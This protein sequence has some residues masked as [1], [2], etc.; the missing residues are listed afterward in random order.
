MKYAEF[1]PHEAL[2]P[3][4]RC[5]WSLTSGS[6]TMTRPGAPDPALPDGCPELIINSADPFCVFTANGTPIRQSRAL[7]V[8]QITGPLAVGPTGRVDLFAVRF[9]PHGAA[10]VCDDLSVITD[11]WIEV[12]DL[13]VSGLLDVADAIHATA[14]TSS[15]CATFDHYLGNVL[16]ARRGPDE[17]VQTAVKAIEASHGVIALDELATT[18]GCTPRHLQRRFATQVGISPK[19]LARIRRF[20]R[21]F[22][23]WRDDPRSLSGVAA[24]CGY[25]D[26]SHLIRDFRDFAGQAPAAFL[27]NQPEFTQFFL[28]THEGAARDADPRGAR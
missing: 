3:F 17:A 20:Q 28:S 1:A 26:Q 24:E 10:L 6:D 13:P 25:F 21:V 12:S 22:V 4:V 14:D 27:A 9:T 5:Y 11:G 15:R 18:L 23:A 16:N 7:L 19:M 2:R 8:G